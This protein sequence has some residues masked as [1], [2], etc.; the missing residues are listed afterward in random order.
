MKA[1]DEYDPNFF[2]KNNVTSSKSAEIIVP[3]IIELVSPRSVIDIGCG[4]GTWLS[5]FK[6]NNV[7]EITGVDGHWVQ[8]EMLLIP[9]SC[10]V[11]HDLTQSLNLERRFDLAVSLEV[12]EHL[13]RKYA[14]NFV[15]TLVKLSSVVAFSA[16]IPFQKG[17]HHVNEEWPDYWAKLFGEHEYVPIDCIREKIWNHKDVAWWYAQNILVFAEKKYVLKNPKLQRASELTRLSQ[18][19]IVHPGKHLEAAAL[20]SPGLKQ[21]LR[22]L[23]RLTI[24]AI[25]YRLNYVHRCCFGGL[26]GALHWYSLPKVLHFFRRHGARNKRCPDRMRL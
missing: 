2:S 5:V 14:R 12:A 10:F 26:V 8:D 19:S 4:T 18:L 17:A 13:D 20:I 21:V 7:D 6:A 9:K 3:L 11:V 22:M 15:S 16:A 23:P 25:K 24:N 1:H